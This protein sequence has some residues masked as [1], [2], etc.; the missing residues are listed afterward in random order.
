MK[1]MAVIS[2]GFVPVPAVDGGA[3][4]VQT[5]YIIE[6]NEFCGDFNIDIYTIESPKLHDCS[7]ENARIIQLH[8]SKWNRF[9]CKAR[10]AFLK[11]LKKR[12]RFIPYNRALIKQF[13]DNYDVV[14]VENNMQVFE[15]IYNHFTNIRN[16]MVYHMHNDIDGTTK[17]E[18]LC[19]FISDKAR[20]IIFVSNYLKK[21]FEIVAPNNKGYILDN[22]IDFD[23]FDKDNTDN[24]IVTSLKNEYKINE[25]EIVFMY[26]G[27][28]CKEKGILEL[29]KAF[30][31]L[32]NNH[33]SAKLM[34]VGSSWYNLIDKDK[35]SQDVLNEIANM[36]DKVV[37]TGYIYPEKMPHIYKLANVVVVPTIIEEAFGMT[38]LEGMAMGLPLIVTNSGGME[39]LA[40]DI[41]DNII[42]KKEKDLID[43]LADAMDELYNLISNNRKYY[44][45]EYNIVP[46]L[47]TYNKKDY[48]GRFLE[49]IND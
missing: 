16:K 47:K 4:E 24:N 39:E 3:G 7:Y 29:V 31:K 41:G 5:T 25:N 1:S 19:K 42:V 18:C 11:I 14:L 17:P 48:Y 33:P 46:R 8:I 44:N 26:T 32:I 23:I 28:I 49:I 2:A 10:N 6:G 34:L 27:R 35:Y 13:E 43:R 37:S 21:H 9:I 22:C 40:K 12:Y 36:E 45:E 30:K 38:A 15:D 20:K